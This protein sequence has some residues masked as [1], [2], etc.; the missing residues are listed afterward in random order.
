MD[1]GQDT[2]AIGDKLTED[3]FNALVYILKRF[4]PF[5]D[6]ININNSIITTDYAKY[7]F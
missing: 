2:F 3:E 6:N 5:T 1:V 4:N 7:I